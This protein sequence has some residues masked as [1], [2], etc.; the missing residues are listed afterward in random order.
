MSSWHVKDELIGIL[1]LPPVLEYWNIDPRR[2]RRSLEKSEGGSSVSF[3]LR[4]CGRPSSGYFRRLAPRSFAHVR[5]DFKMTREDRI[6]L[7]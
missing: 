3:S 4:F 7:W 1:A 6:T 2:T 5:A